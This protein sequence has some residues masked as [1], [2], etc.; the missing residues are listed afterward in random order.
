[1]WATIKSILG[2]K[3]AVMALVAAIVWGVAK[4]GF[5][6]DSETVLGIVSPLVAY[7]LGQSYVDHAKELK[8]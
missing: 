4:L 2:S 8:A 7:I 5:Q 1:M 6:V 3:K